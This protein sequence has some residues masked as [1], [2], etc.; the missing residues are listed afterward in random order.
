M[1]ISGEYGDRRSLKP[2]NSM[3]LTPP[4]KLKFSRRRGIEKISETLSGLL[5][6]I[7]SLC[8]NGCTTD[9]CIAYW[10]QQICA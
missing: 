2:P 9:L 4:S 1:V 5:A 6:L 3:L 10:A 8:V 7:C